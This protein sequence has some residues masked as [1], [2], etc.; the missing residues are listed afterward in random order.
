MQ[1][2]TEVLDARVLIVEH[3]GRIV[4]RQLSLRLGVN[5]YESQVLPHQ[6]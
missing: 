2:V 3:H 6:L 5:P 1:F 4:V